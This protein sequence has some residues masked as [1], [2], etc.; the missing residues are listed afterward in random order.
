MPVKLVHPPDPPPK[1]IVLS[2]R[3]RQSSAFRVVIPAKIVKASGLDREG[4]IENFLVIY[5]PEKPD[6]FI[7]K[8]IKEV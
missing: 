3:G 2:T 1:K 7:L 8:W 6:E 5:N 4:K